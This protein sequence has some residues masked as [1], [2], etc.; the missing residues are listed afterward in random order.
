M[1]LYER[2]RDIAKSKGFSVNRLEQELGFARS[3]ISK[4]NRNTPSAEKIQQIADFLNVSV[5][6]I[7][8]GKEVDEPK[9]QS[10]NVKD[11]K[12]IEKILKQT[13]ERLLSQ[14]GLMFDGKP[15]S[16]ESIDSIL[17]AI[18]VGVEMAKI[19]NKEKY[20]PKKYKKD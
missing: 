19:K 14:E 5:D 3:S 11:E 20:T 15:A 13:E 9:E 7:L 4:F 12:D 10:L 8:N 18:R 1:G 6:Y 16:Q 17:S 2:I